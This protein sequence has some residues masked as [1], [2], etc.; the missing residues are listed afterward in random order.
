[1]GAACW[2][3]KVLPSWTTRRLRAVA[4]VADDVASLAT[5]GLF[6][7]GVQVVVG[8][9][10]DPGLELSRILRS[11]RRRGCPTPAKRSPRRPS[12]A[13]HHGVQ[14]TA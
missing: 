11:P 13:V 6:L 2:R 7:E 4:A 9:P 8:D 10:F 1:M 12:R 14:H 3:S 5:V